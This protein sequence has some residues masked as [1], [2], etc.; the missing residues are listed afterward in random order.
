MA[1]GG[2]QDLDRDEA[3]QLRIAGAIDLSHPARADERRDLV[4]A[5]A[6]PLETLRHE[7]VVERHRRR[8]QKARRLIVVRQQQLDFAAQGLVAVAHLGEV[9]RAGVQRQR[10]RALERLFETRPGFAGKG[11]VRGF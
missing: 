1:N 3:I 10:P 5:N 2:Q 11:H 6:L 8:L 7:A 4:R 9:R